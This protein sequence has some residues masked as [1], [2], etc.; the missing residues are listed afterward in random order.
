[1][2]RSHR[3]AAAAAALGTTAPIAVHA[4]DA[5]HTAIKLSTGA[6]YT[7]GDYGTGQDTDIF[8]VPF[9]FKYETDPW[10]LRL[11]VPYIRITGPGNV[12]GGTGAPI[13]VGT[14]VQNRTTNSGLG[15]VI[16]SIGY[17][18]LPSSRD[19]PLVELT[20]KIK[21]PTASDSKDLGTGEFDYTGQVDVSKSFGPVTP[22]VTLGYRVLGDPQGRDLDNVFFGSLGIGYKLT[23]A[24]GVGAI[25]DWAEASTGAADDAI[26]FTPYLSLK[27]GRQWSTSAY[28]LMGLS[29]GSPDYGGGLQVTFAP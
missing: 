20:G 18:I 5:G 14:G 21:F 3:L 29:D 11:T 19:W 26:E 8:Y 24:L 13:V 6:S 10:S 17:A 12:V 2:K 16:G 15:D 7:T 9:T 27:M 28:A 25:L 22:F 1:M 23:G 4:Q